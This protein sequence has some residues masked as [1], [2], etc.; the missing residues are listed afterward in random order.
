MSKDTI[1]EFKT[2]E[3]TK[4]DPLTGLLRAGA[5]QLIANAVEAE[6]LELLG[7]HADSKDEHGRQ[8][9]VRN[10]YLPGPSAA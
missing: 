5:Q 7:Q 8:V 6:L 10:G 1:I 4:T 2:P 9:I 3:A